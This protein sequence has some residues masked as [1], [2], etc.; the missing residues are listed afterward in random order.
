MHRI[1]DISGYYMIYRNWMYAPT[2]GFIWLRLLVR[3]CGSATQTLQAEIQIYDRNIL[4]KN[5]L[6]RDKTSCAPWPGSISRSC[7]FRKSTASRTLSSELNCQP[8]TKDSLIASS[9]GGMTA[10]HLCTWEGRKQELH[11][12]L[13]AINMANIGGP[14]S[15]EC[16]PQI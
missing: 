14:L 4:G 10:R 5:G 2:V 8:V 9:K 3:P 13:L 1:W 6:W 11:R 12:I 15:V 16:F 7:I